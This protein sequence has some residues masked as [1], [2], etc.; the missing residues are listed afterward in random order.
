ME[1]EGANF[2][3]FEGANGTLDEGE[4]YEN[5]TGFNTTIYPTKTPYY[6]L[7][8]T[9]LY[10][11]DV[12]VPLYGY[13]MPVLLLVTTVANTLI[14][15]VLS[16][17]HMRTPTNT[18]LMAMALSNMMT[19]VFPAPWLFYM[20]T[21][22]NYNTP[23]SS[24]LAC[25]GWSLMHDSLPNLFH[26]ASIWLTVALAV[27]R[28]IYVCH[29]PMARNWCTL[30]RAIK[31][32][33]GIYICAALHQAPR[34]VDVFYWTEYSEWQGRVTAVCAW[35]Y[36]RWIIEYLDLY[37]SLYFGFRV[38]F[39][40]LGPCASLVVLN[41]LLF[42]A[43]RRAQLKRVK[44]LQENKKNESKKLFETNCTTLMLIVIVTVFLV[45]EIPLAVITLVHIITS[46]GLAVIV[47]DY[48]FMKKLIIMSNS[49][50]IFTYPVNFAIYCGM[51]RQFRETFRDLFVRGGVISKRDGSHSSRYSLVNGNRTC[52]QETVL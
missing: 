13:A 41:V 31:T 51:S 38:I 5:V 49:F 30:S 44:L 19:L 46:S 34:L 3:F 12:A 15:L 47:T 14:V 36:A 33:V 20:Y 11:L 32:I 28:Y 1:T 6:I 16:Q 10:P 52:T 24:P 7:N 50:I 42:R 39:V 2:S 21:L 43:M 45:T 40:H 8:L 4:D 23:M 37:F 25:Y 22:D 48:A 26:T 17:T 29:A 9:E 18:I 27:Q 35:H